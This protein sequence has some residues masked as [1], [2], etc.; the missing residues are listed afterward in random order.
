MVLPGVSGGLDG[1][2]SF[3][4][5][6]TRDRLEQLVCVGVEYGVGGFTLCFVP[7][8]TVF[9]LNSFTRSNLAAVNTVIAGK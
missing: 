7:L 6:D 8:L 9:H 4:R 3:A 2:D 1:T 5:L